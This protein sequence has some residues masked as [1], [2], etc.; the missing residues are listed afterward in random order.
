MICL[1][2][3][4]HHR[5]GNLEQSYLSETETKLAEEYLQIAQKYDVKVTLFVTGKTFK[6]DWSDVQELIEFPNLEIGGHTWSAFRPIWLHSTFKSVTGSAYGPKF[7]QS[8]D[9]R[10]TIHIIEKKTGKRPVSWRTHSYASDH[11][12]MD[13]LEAKGIKIVSDEV[14]SNKL[15]PKRVENRKL[16]SLPINVM[17][18][19]EHLYHGARTRDPVKNLID[20]GWKDPFTNKS[21]TADEYYE[22]VRSQIEEIEKNGGIATLLLHPVC[23]KI[24]DNFETFEKICRWINNR[25]YETI[26]CKEV[27]K[28]CK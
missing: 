13:I 28:F 9:I 12:T 11:N 10:K 18:D 21:F 25:E 20:M 3:D 24:A 7:Y 17:P 2:G 1:T 26:W 27:L 19:H 6:E 5:I 16:I 14:S 23:M 15:G 8:I 22:I 4:V